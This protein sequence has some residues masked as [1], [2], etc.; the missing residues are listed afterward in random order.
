MQLDRSL[1]DGK[2]A[3]HAGSRGAVVSGLQDG[4]NAG[5]WHSR[6][7]GEWKWDPRKSR[8]KADAR[9]WLNGIDGQTFGDID[10]LIEYAAR[11]K[12]IA[13]KEGSVKNFTTK[14]RFVTGMGQEHPLQNGFTWH[15]TLGVPYLPGS[16]LKG[17]VQNFAMVWATAAHKPK[18]SENDNWRIFGQNPDKWPGQLQ[19]E[20][21]ET[22][23]DNMRGSVIFLDAVP[24]A[25]VKLSR[26][27]MTPH[28]GD[29]Y[30]EKSGAD[31]PS[32]DKSP[33]P[34]PYL[35]VEAGACF[36]FALRPACP[37]GATD[38][39]QAMCWLKAAL[40][41]IGAGAKTKSGLG[42]FG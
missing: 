2:R 8:P 12:D 3:I 40:E 18:L 39:T 41:M 38:C 33:I 27:V 32:E 10:Q 7:G 25:P 34:V 1:I 29:Y 6:I 11:L 4:G 15:P 28:Y 20:I 37:G 31:W 13:T 16:S 42:R 24:I 30:Q 14:N 22:G 26:T 5:L 9:T 21:T 23:D 35:T 36:Q 17:M 19:P